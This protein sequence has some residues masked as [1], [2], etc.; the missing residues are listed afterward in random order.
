[1]LSIYWGIAAFLSIFPS[2]IFTE[3]DEDDSKFKYVAVFAFLFFSIEIYF[4]RI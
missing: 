2:L 1:M 4:W 3:T